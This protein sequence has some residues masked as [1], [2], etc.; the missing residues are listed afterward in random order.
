MNSCP[1]TC[2]ALSCNRRTRLLTTE[3]KSTVQT[4][5]YISPQAGLRDACLMLGLRLGAD[6]VYE[7]ALLKLII[8]NTNTF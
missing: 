1:A 8:N 3:D 5:N 2:C 4:N 6:S 7:I